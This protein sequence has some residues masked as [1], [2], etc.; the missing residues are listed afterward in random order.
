M[1]VAAIIPISGEYLKEGARSELV[2]K[3]GPLTDH[4]DNFL[5]EKFQCD[6]EKPRIETCYS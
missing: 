2:A 5:Q 3:R 4:F 1:Q 6:T